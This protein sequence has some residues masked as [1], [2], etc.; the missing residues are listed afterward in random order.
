MLKDLVYA[1]RS[2]RRFDE[3]HKIDEEILKELVDLARMSASGMNVQPLKSVIACDE[4]TNGKIFPTLAWAGYLKEWDGPV[5]GERPTGYIIILGD[6]GIR[7]SYG[8]DPGIS[9]QSILL[10]AVEKG[11][12]GCMI[13]SVKREKL[14]TTL[15]IPDWYE[16]LMVI[17]LG[18]PAEKVIVEEVDHDGDIK[19]WHDEKDVHHVPKRAL[20]D[21]IVKL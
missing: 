15:G 18:K 5:K 19:Y 4:E 1:N 13:A 21:I 2:Y 11:L 16:I 8:Y 20:D 10:G 9:G 6:T 7:K 3:K 14:Q 17:A 12:G